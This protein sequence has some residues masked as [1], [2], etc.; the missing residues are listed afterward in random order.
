MELGRDIAKDIFKRINQQKR[1]GMTHILSTKSTN[2]IEEAIPISFQRNQPT[3][4]K[5]GPKS[6]Q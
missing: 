2:K 4:E 5:V 6:S 3:R 1:R